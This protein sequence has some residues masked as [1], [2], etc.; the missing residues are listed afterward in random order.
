MVVLTWV[1]EAAFQTPVHDLA[2]TPADV[3]LLGSESQGHLGQ[4]GAAG[5]FNGDGVDDLLLGVP[6]ADSATG[7]AYIVFGAPG[8]SGVQDFAQIDPDVRIVGIDPGDSFGIS[9]AAGDFNGDGFDD[10]LL[11]AP[12]D[13][14]F[15]DA[16]S[17]AGG[18]YVVFGSATMGGVIQITGLVNRLR[19]VGA[20]AGDALG[21]SVAVG[22]MNGDVFDDILLGAPLA[23]GPMDARPD[24]GEAYVTNGSPSRRRRLR[25]CGRH[26]GPTHSG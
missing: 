17:N 21:T 8:L 22:N 11:G 12:G 15:P 20:T 26:A 5:D 14:G 18:A 19:V 25:R 10:A 1:G 9:V 3:T 16:R 23:D 4:A 2:V 13:D 6:G 24:A 7:D